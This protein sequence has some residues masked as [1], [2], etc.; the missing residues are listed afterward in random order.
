[1]LEFD[2]LQKFISEHASYDSIARF[3][4]PRCYPETR[5]EV[6]KTITDWIDDPEPRQQIFWLN[7]P[8]GAGKSAITQT[9]AERLKDTQLAA[10]FFFQ[11]NTSDRGVAGRLLCYTGMATGHVHTGNSSTS[12]IHTKD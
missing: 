3:P 9:I 7:G 4:P 11:R 12:R 2:R 6:L 1:M 8:A 10:S 5:V